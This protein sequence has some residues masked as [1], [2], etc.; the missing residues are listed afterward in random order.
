MIRASDYL[1]SFSLYT[2][3]GF[4]QLLTQCTVLLQTKAFLNIPPLT[5]D[6][7]FDDS[8]RSRQLVVWVNDFSAFD[9]FRVP[10]TERLKPAGVLY[11]FPFFINYNAPAAHSSGAGWCDILQKKKS[12]V[13]SYLCFTDWK[14]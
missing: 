4:R 11:E 6:E 2:A 9:I 1:P 14:L 5:L 7:M 13:C 10:G 8:N 12:R 3:F